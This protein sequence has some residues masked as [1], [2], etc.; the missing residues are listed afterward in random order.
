MVG[1]PPRGMC[2]DERSPA[3][4]SSRNGAGAVCT[5]A[6]IPIPISVTMN[7]PPTSWPT[8]L[9]RQRHREVQNC[10]GLMNHDTSHV[11]R[12]QDRE[13]LFRLLGSA[14][15]WNIERLRSAL[16]HAEHPFF[17]N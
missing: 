6:M 11:Q 16:G 12:D 2:H 10:A 7:M 4:T 1:G 5:S 17:G 14:V 9:V 13:R 8:A 15:Q 3:M